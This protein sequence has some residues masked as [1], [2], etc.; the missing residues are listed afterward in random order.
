MAAICWRIKDR[1]R[2]AVVPQQVA[3]IIL[4]AFAQRLARP[5]LQSLPRRL[6]WVFLLVRFLL[7]YLIDPSSSTF[8]FLLYS[9]S[10]PFGYDVSPQLI[11]QYDTPNNEFYGVDLP[12]SE[13][14]LINW[15]CYLSCQYSTWRTYPLFPMKNSTILSGLIVFPLFPTLIL[16]MAPP[17]SFGGWSG[18]RFRPWDLRSIDVTVNAAYTPNSRLL[19][20]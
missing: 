9:L 1:R 10:R 18:L 20:Q 14:L 19:R 8:I 3:Y 2:Y 16:G 12:A 6:K 11:R 17:S 7:V 4:L 5:T 15:N 13:S